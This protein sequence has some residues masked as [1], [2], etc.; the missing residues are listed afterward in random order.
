M[1]TVLKYFLFQKKNC[2]FAALKKGRNLWQRNLVCEHC[3][4]YNILIINN[5][6][7]FN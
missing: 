2:T 6:N 4:L 3:A 7:G 5:I 1:I